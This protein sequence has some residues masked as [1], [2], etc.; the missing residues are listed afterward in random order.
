MSDHPDPQTRR[1]PTIDDALT[2]GTGL[3]TRGTTDN[4]IRF[5]AEDACS[6]SVGNGPTHC[7]TLNKLVLAVVLSHQPPTEGFAQT[8]RRLQND[9]QQP[10]N[11]LVTE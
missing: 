8:R 6:M 2:A 3:W 11:A 4:G 7:A 10:I 1:H 5:F 9:R